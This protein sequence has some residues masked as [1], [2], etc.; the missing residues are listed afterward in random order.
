MRGSLSHS[1]GWPCNSIG[2]I[3]CPFSQIEYTGS[4]FFFLVFLAIFRHFQATHLH[5]IIQ[6]TKQLSAPALS[7]Q[8]RWTCNFTGIITDSLFR[9]SQS[10]YQ[11]WC[12]SQFLAMFF[13]QHTYI[14][15]FKSHKNLVHLFI[16]VMRMGMQIDKKYEWLHSS[17][18]MV[19][20]TVTGHMHGPTG[21]SHGHMHGKG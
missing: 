20:G 14:S 16:M 12:F 5:K 15:K 13:L 11:F 18:F 10:K 19:S 21:H 8:C 9:N 17:Q 1:S 2:I 6:I 4:N 3:M 7:W